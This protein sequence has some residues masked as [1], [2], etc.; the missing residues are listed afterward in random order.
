MNV[1]IKRCASR[2]IVPAFLAIV[3]GTSMPSSGAAQDLEEVRMSMAGATVFRLPLYIAIHNGYFK[4]NGLDLQI[5]STRSGSDAMKMLAAN[6]VEFSTGQVLDAINL[7]VQGIDARGVFMMTSRYTNSL[8]VR[9]DLADEIKALADLDGRPLGVTSVGSGTW[10]LAMFVAAQE[11]IDPDTLNF[12]GV[13]TGGNVIGALKA[14]RVA[15]MSYAEPETLQAVNDGDA[16]MLVDMGDPETHQRLIGDDYV[17]NWIM[18][19]GSY[20]ESNPETVQ[21][22]VNAM[23]QGLDWVQ[24]KTPAEVAETLSKVTGFDTTDIGVLEQSIARQG[25]PDSGVVTPT[26]FDNTLKVPRT[27]GALKEEMTMEQLVINSFAENAGK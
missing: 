3:A 19:L 22:F 27:A 6:S 23:Q 20:A 13:G 9:D 7:N 21:K 16:K 1:T 25:I 5:V 2:F 17:S 4:D 8:L 14:D 12:V 24:G 10:Q 11:G 26:A 18:V 15:V